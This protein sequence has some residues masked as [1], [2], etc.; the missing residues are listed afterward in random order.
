VPQHRSNE[1]GF[2]LTEICVA[3]AL[4]VLAATGVA[5]LFAVAVASTYVARVQT[6]TTVF[7]AQKVEALRALAWSDAALSATPADALDSNVAGS[8]EHL[9]ARGVVVSVS[10]AA[11]PSGR[12]IR[13]WSIRPL[14]EDSTNALIVQV[15][16]TAAEAERRATRPRQRVAGDALVTTILAR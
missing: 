2:T 5:N 14:P 16:V 6:S 12:F 3:M 8:V 4:L 13:R 7:A 15:L 1:L 9:D 10:T 11:P